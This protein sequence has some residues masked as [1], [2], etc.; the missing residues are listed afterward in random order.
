MPRGARRLALKVSALMRFLVACG[1]SESARAFRK[2]TQ[3]FDGQQ[4]KNN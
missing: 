1:P 4:M 2:F 3:Q